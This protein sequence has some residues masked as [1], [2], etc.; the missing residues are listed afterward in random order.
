MDAVPNHALTAWMREQGYSSRELADR[1][2]QAVGELT[3]KLG[4]LDDSSIRAWRS[5]RVRCPKSAQRAALELISGRT[6]LALGFVRRTRTKDQEL[7]VDRRTFIT[8][9]TTAAFS[10]A[11]PPTAAVPRRVGMADVALIQQRFADII[12]SDH[13]HGGQRG[14]EQ[15]AAALAD[16]ALM[17]QTIGTASQ[18][19]RASLYAAAAS[20][21]SSAMWA[22]I[23]G[24]RFGDASNHMREAQS[25]AELAG[26]PAIKFRIWSHAGTMYRHMG[27]PAEAAAAN[28]VARGLG[29][30]RRDPMF[31][32]LGLARHAAIH[33]AAGDRGAVR[34]SFGQARE[35]M[36]RADPGEVR[37]LWLTAFYDTAEIDSLALSA[38]SMLGDWATAEAHGHRCLAGLRPHMVRSKAITTAR[39]ARAQLEQGEVESAVTSAMGVSADAAAGHPRVSAML[40]TFGSRLQQIAPGSSHADAWRS[41]TVRLK[42]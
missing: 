29:L 38:Y 30:T 24:R 14:I 25:L 6:A 3:G 32:S 13:R 18:R 20:F 12:A 35:A 8:A 11:A 16:E 7:S 2:N 42:V 4:G 9:A 40:A 27:R 23:D 36:D 21:R 37:P 26:D 31:A 34:R 39:L 33:A 10:A 5:G 19:V 41:H 1:V 15:Q 28:D 22:A 17:C